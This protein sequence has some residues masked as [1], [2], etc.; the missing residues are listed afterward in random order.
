MGGVPIFVLALAVIS[1]AILIGL[2]VVEVVAGKLATSRRRA[3]AF[4]FAFVLVAAVGSALVF[5][6]APLS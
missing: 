5:L 3:S 6:F 2:L 1:A 4:L